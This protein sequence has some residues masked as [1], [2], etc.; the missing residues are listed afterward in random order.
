MSEERRQILQMLAEGQVTADEADRLLDALGEPGTPTAPSGV[1]DTPPKHRPRYLRVMVDER[2]GEEGPTHVNVRVPMQLLRAGVRL[3]SLIPEV[4][5][6][7]IN[8]ALAKQG[9]TYDVAQLRPADLEDLVEHLSDL[10]VDVDQNEGQVK[11]RV[12]A[13]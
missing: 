2:D 1:Q 4:A 7:P 13:E 8:Q 11:V 12:F 6:D 3:A 5:R 10:S 9:I